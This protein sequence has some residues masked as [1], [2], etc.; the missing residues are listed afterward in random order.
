MKKLLAVGLD[1]S[2]ADSNLIAMKAQS[3]K[4]RVAPGG[5]IDLEPGFV[6]LLCLS[7]MDIKI[8]QRHSLNMLTIGSLL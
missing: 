4:K 6:I 8:C 1:S 3:S 2:G 5:T 7:Q